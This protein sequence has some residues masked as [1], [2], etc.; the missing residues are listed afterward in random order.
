MGANKFP[1]LRHFEPEELGA[2]VLSLANGDLR[3]EAMKSNCE[4]LKA[5]KLLFGTALEIF[6]LEGLTEH[7]RFV[8]D[9]VKGLQLLNALTVEG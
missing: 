2:F 3:L 1:K 8:L 4:L 9:S 5:D 6:G 7:L